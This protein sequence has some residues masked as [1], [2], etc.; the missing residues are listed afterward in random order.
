MDFSLIYFDH[1]YILIKCSK[2][3]I[4]YRFC[5]IIVLFQYLFDMSKRKAK[6]SGRSK[7]I[8]NSQGGDNNDHRSF[9]I[10]KCLMG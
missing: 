8:N 6:I 5:F 9:V 10:G 2:G 7:R 3:Q 1:I 4:N